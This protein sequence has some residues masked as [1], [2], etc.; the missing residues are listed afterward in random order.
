M[1]SLLEDSEVKGAALQSSGDAPGGV[2]SAMDRAEAPLAPSAPRFEP[3]V[4]LETAPSP[5]IFNPWIIALVVTMGTFME[6]LDTSIANV[7]LPHIAGSL[8][9]SQDESTWVLTSYLVA[10]AIILPISG[11]ISSVLGRKNF[12]LISVVMFT[13]FSACCGIAPTLGALVVFRVLQGLSGGGLQPSVQAILA[14][15]F[16]GEKRG[17]AMAVYTVAILCA[18]VLGPTLGGWITD[19]YSW[20]WIFYINIPVGVL[21]AFFTRMVLVDPP[22]L[23]KARAAR[24][25]KPL[26]IDGT[27][28]ALVS[29]GLAAME[30]VLDRGQELDWFGSTFITWSA[31]VAAIAIVG[32][33]AWE[34]HVDNPVVNLRLLKERNFLFCCTIVL[35]MYTALY[36]STFLLPQ[37]MQELMGYD[38][39]TAGIAVSPAGL[40]TMLEVP[41]VGWL[42]SRGTDARRLIACGIVTMT[43]GTYFCS[44]MNL[45]VSEGSMIWPRIV[46]VMGLGMT[47]VPLSTIMF[48]FLPTEQSSNAAGI[49][50]LVRNEGGS[51]GIALSSTLLQRTTQAHQTYLGA[52]LSA[53]NPMVAQ[54][55]HAGGAAVGGAMADQSYGGLALLYAQLQRQASLLAYMDQFRLFAYLLACLL[56]L[57]LLLKRPPRIIGKITLDAH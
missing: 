33:I 43:A 20:R 54:T 3:G 40:V 44:L 42:M 21:C 25:G 55:I 56:P 13:V 22:H 1:Q 24:K 37:Y 28:L 50:A 45:Q 15:A 39:T 38:A 29:I 52:Q 51:I 35:G 57:V 10:N 2:E 34:L 14:D 49:Y 5:R 17:M 19:N 31:I 47:T 32:A 6:V 7:A 16:P 4:A 41:F 9:A 27:G 11:W 8:S 26:Q 30:I 48:R 53:S 36:A 46:Q 18:P 23:V 12:Y